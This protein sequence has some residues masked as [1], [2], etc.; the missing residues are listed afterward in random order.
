MTMQTYALNPGRLEK[1]SGAISKHSQTT[2]VLGRGGRQVAMPKNSSR[3]YMARRWLPYGATATDR[4]TI[5]RFFQDG[6]GDR[7]AAIVQAHQTNEGVTPLPESVVPQD[8]QVVM[9]QYSCLYGF[10]DQAFDMYEDK[11]PEQMVMQVSERLT[12]VNEMIIYG[13]LK[14]CTNQFFGGVGTSIGTVNG[15]LTLGLVRKIVLNLQANS[16]M[17]VTTMLG[18]SAYID[19]TPVSAGYIVYSH[20]DMEGDIRDLPDF[21]PV[22]KYATGQAMPFEI[23][24]CERF[25]FITSPSFPSLQNAGA[26]VGGLNLYSTTGTNADVYPVIVCAKDAWSQIALRGKESNDPTYLPPGEKSKSDPHGQRGYAGTKWYK[27]VLIENNG[28]MAVANV[29]RR[30]SAA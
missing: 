14:A 18:A 12:F 21:T 22:E 8:I 13:A 27:A 7:A 4:N 23:G 30:N 2:E 24:K 19:T 29:A 1:F 26:V 6:N 3:T 5:N 10:S 11:I 15:A 17:P 25:R 28:W 9:Q 16:A 20:T